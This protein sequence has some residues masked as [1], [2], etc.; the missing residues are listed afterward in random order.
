VGVR[1]RGGEARFVVSSSSVRGRCYSVDP[2]GWR[3]DCPD[4]RR[5]GVACKHVLAS[6]VLGRAARAPARSCRACVGGWVYVGEDVVD[7]ETRR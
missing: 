4:F 6:Y 3:C 2:E 7:S 5:R 1:V